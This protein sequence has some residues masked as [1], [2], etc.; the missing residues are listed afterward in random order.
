MPA[1]TE[2]M[3][4]EMMMKYMLNASVECHI[5]RNDFLSST[6]ITASHHGSM[7][8]G[9]SEFIGT[10]SALAEPKLFVI[11]SDPR[12]GEE[13]PKVSILNLA[14]DHSPIVPHEFCMAGKDTMVSMYCDIKARTWKKKKKKKCDI[15]LSVFYHPLFQKFCLRDFCNFDVTRSGLSFWI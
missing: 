10:F 6:V 5:E 13:L 12:E 4:L 1:I 9:S 15:P 8:N 3:I 11:C 7:T 2:E 14:S